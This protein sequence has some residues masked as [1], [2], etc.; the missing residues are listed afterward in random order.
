MAIKDFIITLYAEETATIVND[1][2]QYPEISIFFDDT[3]IVDNIPVKESMFV[4]KEPLLPSWTKIVAHEDAKTN[5]TE[6][7]TFNYKFI[8]TINDN[9]DNKKVDAHTIKVEFKTD[10]KD[11]MY[12]DVTVSQIKINNMHLLLESTVIYDEEP[13]FELEFEMPVYQH[14][15]SKQLHTEVTNKTITLDTSETYLNLFPTQVSSRA[16]IGHECKEIIINKIKDFYYKDDVNLYGATTKQ[17]SGGRYQSQAIE[18]NAENFLDDPTL[19]PLWLSLQTAFDEH[20]NNFNLPRVIILSTWC[21]WYFQPDRVRPGWPSQFGQLSGHIHPGSV[22]VGTY[23][24]FIEKDSSPV[25]YENPFKEVIESNN[26]H[27]LR[28]LSAFESNIKDYQVEE[29]AV[30]AQEGMFN[31]FPAYLKHMV[32]PAS[33]QQ[34]MVVSCNTCLYSERH[35]VASPIHPLGARD[36]RIEPYDNI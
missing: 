25:I 27:R 10:N 2:I 34:R 12:T 15:V 5:K 29:I 28:G 30:H 20:C 6:K 17:T 26:V 33:T 9:V 3:L 35:A 14:I 13:V 11:A 19:Y 23:Y 16:F 18:R 32:R 31:I 21:I 7:L 36:Y 4:T 8:V 22:L 24:P 1:V